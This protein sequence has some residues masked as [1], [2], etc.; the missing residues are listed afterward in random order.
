MAVELAVPGGIGHLPGADVFDGGFHALLVLVG[1]TVV[2]KG[3]H[4]AHPLGDGLG[5]QDH[6][7]LFRQG[8]GLLG[9]HDDVFVVGQDEHDLRRGAVDG[10]ED[11][12]GGG[13][14][15]LA[16][17]H[18]LL[19][20]QLLEESADPLAGGNRDEAIA[21]HGGGAL[22]LAHAGGGL[23]LHLFPV[24]LDHVFHLYRDELAELQA[25]GQGAVGG[26]GM[27]VDLDDLVIL[28]HHHAVADGG[29]E[30][31]HLVGILAGGLPGGDELGA[32]VKIDLPLV[33]LGEIG[34]LHRHGRVDH[35][36]G[37]LA[38]QTGDGARDG[39]LH[40]L[41]DEDIAKGSGVHHT[42]F[43]QDGVLVDGLVQGLAGGLDGGG[44]DG[45]RVAGKLGGLLRRRA[46]D[47]GNGED[48]AFRRLHDGL[49]GRGAAL[50][51]GVGQR[52]AVGGAEILQPLC[53]APEEEGGDDPGIAPGPPQK[54]AA[55]HV[56][57]PAQGGIFQLG[58]LL[59]RVVQ[60]H[61]H[62][63][64]RVPIGDGEDV[65]G[66]DLLHPV[67]HNASRL[68]DHV[69]IDFAIDHFRQID[70]LLTY[71]QALTVSTTMSIRPT[72]TPHSCCTR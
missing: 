56:Q 14:H 58:E 35:G 47:A 26:V 49:I 30:L 20:A 69:F 62:I 10:A 9:G 39:I 72:S 27:D 12:L 15:G 5:G 70:C 22:P 68:A 24:L 11:V 28:H 67:F 55:R 59:H 17:L 46:R 32:V 51:Q 57:S 37:D 66:V 45:L 21:G 29:Q 40:P 41:E 16:A 60:G 38:G 64:A 63:G 52:R 7:L 65:E 43:F 25:L 48:G 8:G 3:Q 42:G 1:L 6:H 36:D 53:D 2:V 44:E 18:D 31:A 13:V 71:G 50:G 61:G 33:E 23:F 4:G 54:G 19:G 34:P